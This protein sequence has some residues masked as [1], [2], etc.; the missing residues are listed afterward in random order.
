MDQNELQR[1]LGRLEGKVDAA[2]GLITSLVADFKEDRARTDSA[3]SALTDRVTSTEKKVY[4]FSGIG[5]A[6]AWF[7]AT[8]LPL[9]G[10]VT[11]NG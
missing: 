5:A 8:Y 6:I 3:I 10:G 11:P 7:A 2:S 9:G 4:W 1:D